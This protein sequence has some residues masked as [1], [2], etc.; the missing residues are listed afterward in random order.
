MRHSP[1]HS[2]AEDVPTSG[3]DHPPC[4]C[5]ATRTAPQMKW[6]PRASTLGTDPAGSQRLTKVDG[7]TRHVWYHGQEREHRGESAGQ[8]VCGCGI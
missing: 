7:R 5:A 8:F 6:A 4:P 1:K 2:A 3:T